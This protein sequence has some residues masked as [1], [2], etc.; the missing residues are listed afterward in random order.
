[1]PWYKGMP[2]AA[3]LKQ[4][5]PGCGQERGIIHC[6]ECCLWQPLGKSVW[7]ILK[8]LKTNCHMTALPLLGICRKNLTSQSTGTCLVVFTAAVS[9]RARKWKP[10]KYA[11]EDEWVMKMW[12]IYTV[13]QYAAE[14]VEI[15]KWIGKW[16]KL[17]SITWREITQTQKDKY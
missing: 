17:E 4:R 11:S 14:K 9:T 16:I 3:T 15:L 2:F 6:S 5:L 8:K 1:M 7:R 10:P 12:Y 13:E